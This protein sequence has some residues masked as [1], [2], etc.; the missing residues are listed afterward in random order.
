MRLKIPKI[1]SPKK[2]VLPFIESGSELILPESPD[3]T[4][5]LFKK[6]RNAKHAYGS[7]PSSLSIWG[8]TSLPNIK[9]N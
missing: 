9:T 7:T 2:M 6:K 1:M 4:E 5:G 8:Q 3:I